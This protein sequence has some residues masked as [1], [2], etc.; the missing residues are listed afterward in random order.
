LITTKTNPT[1]TTFRKLMMIFFAVTL[2]GISF[3]GCKSEDEPT[4]VGPST[5]DPEPEIP[6]TLPVVKFG[7]LQVVGNKIV[8]KDGD[9]VQLRGMSFFWSQ[10]IGK[11][12]NAATVKWLKDDWRCNIVRAAMAVEE[13]GYLLQ[14][15]SEKK[16]VTD[17][18]DAAIDEGIYVIIDWHDHHA[19]NNTKKAKE[20]FAQMAQQYGDTPNVIYELFNEPEQVSWTNQV[21]PYHQAVIDTIR[22]YDPDN[23]IICGTTTWSQDV[24]VAANDPLIGT[25]IAYTLHFYAGSHKQFLR[26]KATTALNK[27]VALMVTEFGTTDASG[28]GAVDQVETAKWFQFL[29]EHKISWCNWSIADKEEGS[30]ALKP[31]AGNSGGWSNANLTTSGRFIKSEL[32]GKNPLIKQD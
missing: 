32:N 7:K 30:A 29:D 9:P 28:D 26:D 27:G 16:K 1:M 15:V 12:Y 14:P 2:A 22:F 19:F 3:Q 11:Y 20:F 23:L 24:D 4:P 31:G 6:D 17:V 8:D 5:P 18:V 13:G 10:W 21:K 25:N